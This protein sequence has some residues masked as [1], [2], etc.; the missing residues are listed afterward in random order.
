M[1]LYIC[2]YRSPSQVYKNLKSFCSSCN[3]LLSNINDQHQACSI[4]IEDL[5]AKCSKW[6][7]IY[8]DNTEGH[9]IDSIAT[10]AG[11]S[12]MINKPTHFI[13]E[14]SSC[15]DLIFSS[16]TSFIKNCGSELSIHEKC[17]RHNIYETLNFDIPLPPPYY[18]D[19]WDYKHANTENI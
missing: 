10:T 14:S 1:L 9:E 12:Q 7:T 16:N 6:C 15:I 2:L 17:H 4:V 13:N 5:N 19:V 8:K 11:H 18:R 3:S